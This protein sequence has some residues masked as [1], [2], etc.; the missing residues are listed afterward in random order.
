M[1]KDYETP[2]HMD[3]AAAGLIRKALDGDGDTAV[4]LIRMARAADNLFGIEQTAIIV[5]EN[6]SWTQEKQS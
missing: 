4:R 5:A 6:D 2:S 3:E 1:R